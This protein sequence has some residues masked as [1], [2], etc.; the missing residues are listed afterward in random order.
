[1]RRKSFRRAARVAFALALT[2]VASLLSAHAWLPLVGALVGARENPGAADAIAVHGG[3]AARTAY[4]VALLRRGAAPQLWHTSYP[5][6]EK[7]ITARV[8]A[9]GVP[10]A[11]FRW[12]SSNSTWND[13]EQF[14]RQVREQRLDS[15]LV[16]TDW[17]HGRR[18]LCADR[19]NLRGEPITIHY[20]AAPATFGPENWWHDPKTRQN[21]LSELVKLAYYAVRYGM[22]PWRC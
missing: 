8:L 3:S 15:I 12:L 20:T 13:A 17:W 19:H 18:A 21:V 16:V 11:S 1:M 22:W 6:G 9:S 14:A 10:P 5:R 4:G 2:T 7:R